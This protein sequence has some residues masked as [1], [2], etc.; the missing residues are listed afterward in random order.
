MLFSLVQFR[1]ACFLY[2]KNRAKH[3]LKLFLLKKLCLLL[4]T[5]IKAA[6]INPSKHISKIYH[7]NPLK[8]ALCISGC[9]S[10]VVDTS[11]HFKYRM[12]E[13][14]KISFLPNLHLHLGLFDF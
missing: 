13:V 14:E 4:W 7:N 5:A 2:F 9:Y 8:I 6:N 1:Q 10:G 11:S 12:E 3:F